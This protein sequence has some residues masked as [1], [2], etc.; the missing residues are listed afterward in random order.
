MDRQSIRR[1]AVAGTWYPADPLAL[2]DHVERCL[3]EADEPPGGAVSAI[4]APHA[5]LVFSGSVAGHAY[6]ALRG[7]ACDAVVLVGPSHY[8]AFDGVSIQSG[9]A[10]DT[11]LGLAPI[12]TRIAE[13]FLDSSPVVHVLPSAHEREHSLE[14][15]LPFL[16]IVLPDAP[17]V[18]LVMGF[19]TRPTIDALAE[20]L[21]R[22][23]EG[24]RAV[25]V[26]STDL[27]HFFDAGRAARLD[28]RVVGAVSRFDPGALL[29]EL[30]SY[31]EHE[32]G[33]YVACGGGP[34]VSVM[35][36]ARRLGASQARI[37]KRA[38]SSDVSGDTSS[39]V[40]YLAA[41]FGRFDDRA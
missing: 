34:M 20:A 10:Y 7:C 1:S 24:R 30:E 3:G 36:A 32:R 35:M 31:P 26:A 33:R 15:Q 9:G 41:A 28:A 4:V 5:G 8:V 2:R 6:R 25:L 16:R 37:L 19:Q 13:A 29:D 17:I 22:V 39:V 14:M 18:P 23:L 40:G 11:P 27:S 12:E 38:D 21:V